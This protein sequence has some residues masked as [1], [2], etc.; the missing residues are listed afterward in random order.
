MCSYTE[1]ETIQLVP[2]PSPIN[3]YGRSIESDAYIEIS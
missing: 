1:F 3:R 2:F